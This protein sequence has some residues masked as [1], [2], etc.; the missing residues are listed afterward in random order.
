M[1][2]ARKPDQPEIDATASDA[3]DA[4]ASDAD[5]WNFDEDE[6]NLGRPEVIR[7]RAYEIWQAGGKVGQ[8]QDYLWRA[9]RQVE[10]EENSDFVPN[11]YP[12]NREPTEDN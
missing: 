11:P 9:A 5:D 12:I 1:T 4:T 3:I 8:P 7:H 10:A 2:S 6:N